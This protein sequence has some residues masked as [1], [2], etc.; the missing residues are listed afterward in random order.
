MLLGLPEVGS[1]LVPLIDSA[2]RDSRC[3]SF[4][5][6]RVCQELQAAQPATTTTSTSINPVNSSS[7]RELAASNPG[8]PALNNTQ[9]CVVWQA[10]VQDIEAGQELCVSNT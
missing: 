9:L 3:S 6:V 2:M 4:V 5:E 1:H 8:P 7:L 10:G